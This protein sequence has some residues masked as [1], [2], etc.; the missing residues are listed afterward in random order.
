MGLE[1]DLRTVRRELEIENSKNKFPDC[2]CDK[3]TRRLNKLG[4]KAING[5]VKD[6]ITGDTIMGHWWNYDSITGN[7]IDLTLDQFDFYKKLGPVVIILKNS[8]LAQKI[9]T[10]LKCFDEMSI[11]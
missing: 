4:F 6:P 8:E 11:L 1:E 5:I 3:A 2:C 10:E 7:Y 9:Y